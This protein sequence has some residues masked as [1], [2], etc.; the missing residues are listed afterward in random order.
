MNTMKYVLIGRILGSFACSDANSPAEKETGLDTASVTDTAD[1]TDTTDTTDVGVLV[2]NE[3]APAP[4]DTEDWIEFYNSTS[5][6]AD[7]S[8][9]VIGDNDVDLVRIGDLSED[10][11]VPA[12]SFLLVYTK[13]TDAN[14][15]DVGFGIKKDGSEALYFK[16]PAGELLSITLPATND[17][18]SYGRIPDGSDTWESG[19]VETPSAF[20]Q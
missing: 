9:W 14:G 7:V 13:I 3:I 20:H 5:E 19:L 4:L 6:A 12:G 2:I 8:D 15:N 16:Q 11:I 17:G 1:T 10:S 18:E